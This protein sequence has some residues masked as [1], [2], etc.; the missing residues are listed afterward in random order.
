MKISMEVFVIMEMNVIIVYMHS[1]TLN[2]YGYSVK[3]FKNSKFCR[4]LKF[5]SNWLKKSLL[6]QFLI[7]SSYTAFNY[8]TGIILLCFLLYKFS[9]HFVCKNIIIGLNKLA[10]KL[11]VKFFYNQ[12]ICFCW[13]YKDFWKSLQV[14]PLK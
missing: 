10:L 9:V 3:K 6:R 14:Q 7:N 8:S 5:T 12:Q 13:F 2:S 11:T 4:N 1:F